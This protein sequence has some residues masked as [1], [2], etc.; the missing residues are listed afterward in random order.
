M[1]HLSCIPLVYKGAVEGLTASFEVFTRR[2][3]LRTR[4]EIT[5]RKTPLDLATQFGHVGW[6]QLLK[7][8]SMQHRC[9]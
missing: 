6:Q 3:A 4:E 2:M 9:L 5:R 8:Q 1:R 7:K